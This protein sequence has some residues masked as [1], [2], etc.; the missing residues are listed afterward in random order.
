ML[1]NVSMAK[2]V[3]NDDNAPESFG[4]MFDIYLNYSTVFEFGCCQR[5]EQCSDAKECLIK[6][7]DPIFARGCQ[8]RKNLESGRIFYGKNRII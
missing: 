4:K 7:T 1:V 2:G 5:Y 6:D 8:Y 3:A